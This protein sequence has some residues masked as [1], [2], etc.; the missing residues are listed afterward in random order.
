MSWFLV[1]APLIFVVIAYLGGKSAGKKEAELEYAKKEKTQS[2][3]TDEI[4]DNNANL[5]A[6][7]FDSWLQNHSKK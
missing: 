2:Q 3:E 7:E 1:L 4:I 5:T 6:D